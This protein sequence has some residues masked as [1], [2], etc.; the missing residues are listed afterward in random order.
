MCEACGGNHDGMCQAQCDRLDAANDRALRET[1]E[2]YLARRERQIR[3]YRTEGQRISEG[4]FIHDL[5]NMV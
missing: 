3:R 5:G 1:D 4:F 2:D